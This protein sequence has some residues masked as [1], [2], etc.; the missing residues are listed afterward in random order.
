[1]ITKPYGFHAGGMSCGI[2]PSGS[3]DLA[4]VASDRPC[5]A[6]GVFTRNRFC[7]A[8]VHVS[9]RHVRGGRAQAIV[10][11]SGISNV[12]T[13][14]RGIADAE[15]MCEAVA[16]RLGEHEAFAGA[17]V[18]RGDVL[19]ASTGIIGRPLPMEKITAGIAT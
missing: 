1:M 5:A 9:K 19:P 18:A 13:G 17:K 6:A 3:P 8:P 15:A 2:K 4:I 10:C 16:E 7:G 12:G 11:N 14:E